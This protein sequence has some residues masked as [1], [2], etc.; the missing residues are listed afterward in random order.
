MRFAIPM[1]VVTRKSTSIV[2][3]EA[4][5]EIH[6]Q[7]IWWYMVILLF[8]PALWTEG[9]T[10]NWLEQSSSLGFI[11]LFLANNLEWKAYHQMISILERYNRYE[12]VVS[13]ISYQHS[14]V[15]YITRY[16]FHYLVVIQDTHWSV[17]FRSIIL[18]T[19]VLILL[20]WGGASA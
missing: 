5:W 7:H 9:D 16:S 12:L 20:L 19:I 1:A 14:I 6:P 10:M 11:R 2:R 15:P 8:F 3:E 13:T 4:T 17:L 18:K